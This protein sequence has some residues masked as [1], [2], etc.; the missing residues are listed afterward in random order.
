MTHVFHLFVYGTLRSGAEAG[1]LLDG[2]ERVGAATITGTLYDVNDRYPALMLY[3]ATPVR[4]EIWRCPVELLPRL[5]EYEG[6]NRRLFRRVGVRVGD[7]P[8]WT[9]VAGPALARELKPTRRITS[10]E[11]LS[12]GT[13]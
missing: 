1:R 3:G 8:C 12:P 9:Y 7:V 6:V 11:W 5:D 4:G 10:G 2:C 13:H